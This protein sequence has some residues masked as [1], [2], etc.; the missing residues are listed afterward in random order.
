LL[1]AGFVS[2]LGLWLFAWTI[3]VCVSAS[4]LAFSPILALAGLTLA[5]RPLLAAVR[6]PDARALIVAEPSSRS[7][8]SAG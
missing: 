3:Y 6:D 4:L 8:A 2:T 1:I 5:R 7:G